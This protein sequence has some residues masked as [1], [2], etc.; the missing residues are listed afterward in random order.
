[1]SPPKLASNA[2][3]RKT[4]WR[5]VLPIHPACAAYPRL[6]EGELRELAADIKTNGLQVGIVLFKEG[7]QVS[8]LDGVSRLDAL[9]ANGIDLIQDGKLDHSLGLGSGNRVRVVADVDPVMMA[10]SLNIARRH[11]TP[12]QKRQAV[13]ALI[14][15][16]PT[17]SD[18]AIAKVAKVDDKTVAAV[19]AEKE[20]T[21][22][23]PQ[24]KTRVGADGKSRKQPRPAKPDTDGEAAALKQ[25]RDVFEAVFNDIVNDIG[26]AAPRDDVGPESTGEFARLQA[27]NSELENEAYL[28]RSEVGALK[29]ELEELRAHDTHVAKIVHDLEA[30]IKRLEAENKAL[31]AAAGGAPAAD[32]APRTIEEAETALLAAFDSLLALLKGKTAL[33]MSEVCG[34]VI[35][36]MFC[37]GDDAQPDDNSMEEYLEARKRERRSQGAKKA[38]APARRGRPSRNR[39]PPRSSSR[40]R[41]QRRSISKEEMMTRP[42]T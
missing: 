37:R 32:P 18:R 8:L 16:D 30:D 7:D 11:L 19:R 12:E 5:D 6:G 20:A 3:D 15:Q 28:L 14:K 2:G 36:E 4:S 41:P 24:L 35:Q 33:Q 25:G 34:E 9:E 1:M 10:A 27:R 29:S 13:E 21:A 22:E 38:A 42:N 39:R 31:K 26:K 40:R 23:I 17:R